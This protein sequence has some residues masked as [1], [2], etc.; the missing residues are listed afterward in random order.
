PTASSFWKRW[1]RASPRPLLEWAA[2]LLGAALPLALF[3]RTYHSPENLLRLDQSA[4]TGMSL[5]TFFLQFGVKLV[6]L[7]LVLAVRFSSIQSRRF[8][9]TLAFIAAV[10]GLL[11]LASTIGAATGIML[12]LWLALVLLGVHHLHASG[13]LPF[14]LFVLFVAQSLDLFPFLFT[15][16]DS[17]TTFFKFGFVA[18]VVGAVGIFMELGTVWGTSIL[19]R[20]AAR[21]D[22]L[23][24][25]V[26]TLF[27]GSWMPALGTATITTWLRG[28]GVFTLDPVTPYLDRVYPAENEAI[29]WLAAHAEDGEVVLEATGPAFTP[30]G[31]VSSFTG[32]PPVINWYTHQLLWHAGQPEVLAEIQQRIEDVNRIYA[33]LDP[34]EARRLLEKYGVVYVFVGGVERG[35]VTREGVL[36]LHWEPAALAKFATFMDVVYPPSGQ[37]EG[38]DV[39]IYRTRAARRK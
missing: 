13:A 21:R 15:V 2:C 5:S 17:P 33:T 22:A 4:A 12:F 27:V 11:V 39:V 31:R 19:G 25:L 7:A 28:R 9:V 36:E 8:W 6:C 10:I 37:V 20:Q 26:V 3:A 23:T 30:A 29:R 32:L 34:D 16:H 35:A 38:S 14:S 1:A 24:L 18:W